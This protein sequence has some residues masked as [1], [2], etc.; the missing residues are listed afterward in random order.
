MTGDDFLL[1]AFWVTMSCLAVLAA[2]VPQ[3]K[4]LTEHGR[5]ATT[6]RECESLAGDTDES[7]ASE[8]LRMLS[9]IKAVF[10][11]KSWFLHFYITGIISSLY[12]II[13]SGRELE[14]YE[15]KVAVLLMFCLHS[16]RRC[17]E[18]MYVIKFGSSRMH[19][20]GYIVGLIY[21]VIV[22]ITLWH[23]ARDRVFS[24]FELRTIGGIT[25]FCVGTLHKA[26]FT[27][28]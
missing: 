13:I 12:F 19:I 5:T 2:T 24:I 6:W 3:L 21:Y 26:T 27:G 18:C 22:P 10:V 7:L 28:C 15:N 8:L 23:E 11:N 16:V 17:Y 4:F 9:L 20:A 14:Y 25:L 1:V